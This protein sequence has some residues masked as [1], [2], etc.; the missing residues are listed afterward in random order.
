MDE[1]FSGGFKHM[2]IWDKG[3]MGMGH[4][5]RRSYET[6]LVAEKKGAKCAWY[7][8]SKRVENVIRPRDFGIRKIIPQKHHHPTEK[9]WQLAARFLGLHT[10]PG[11]LV[12]DPFSGGGSTLV[13]CKQM[14]R[15]AIG[16]EMEERFCEIAAGKLQGIMALS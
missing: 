1:A 16:V 2:V 4:H 12:V 6:I 9:P 10:L 14:G 15:K 11:H 3:P 8:T 5:Y 13:A 7:D